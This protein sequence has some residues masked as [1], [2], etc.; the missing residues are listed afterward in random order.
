MP[1]QDLWSEISLA[2]AA[3]SSPA[4]ICSPQSCKVDKRPRT[5]TSAQADSF[6]LMFARSPRRASRARRRDS[7]K[8]RPNVRVLEVKIKCKFTILPVFDVLLAAGRLLTRCNYYH[9]TRHSRDQ[10]G[11]S[12]FY[13]DHLI[14]GPASYFFYFAHEYTIDYMQILLNRHKI[15]TQLIFYKFSFQKYLQHFYNFVFIYLLIIL[16]RIS[17]SHILRTRR[18]FLNQK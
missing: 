12:S 13:T 9:A 15:A 2:A 4:N 16:L 17:S 6:Y 10:D 18:W 5:R 7:R 3:T 8:H 14:W 1:R 11:R